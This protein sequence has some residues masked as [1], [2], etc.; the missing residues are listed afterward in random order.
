VLDAGTRPVTLF[1]S[2]RTA[3]DAIDRARFETWQRHRPGFRY[4][5]TLTREPHADRCRRIPALLPNAFGDL[6]GWEV[7]VSGPPGFVVACAAAARAL[8]TVA[9]DVHTEEFFTDPQP[10]STEP[11]RP[12]T[13]LGARS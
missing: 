13:P 8:G 10:W 5:L 7:F 11:D 3:D 1:F 6:S 2:G 9:V 12:L 4:L